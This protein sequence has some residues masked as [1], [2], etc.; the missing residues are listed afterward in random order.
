MDPREPYR[1]HIEHK[2]IIAVAAEAAH[3]QLP[4]R[5]AFW[6]IDFYVEGYCLALTTNADTDEIIATVE[7]A[8]AV[9]PADPALPAHLRGLIGR[10]FGWSWYAVNS[11][12]YCDMLI[13]AFDGIAPELAFLVEA[14][15]IHVSRI[16]SLEGGRWGNGPRLR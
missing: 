3:P 1:N 9:P 11:Q 2:T 6:R 7:P 14:S 10:R 5:A 4:E 13:L 8:A 12:G 16:A 15:K